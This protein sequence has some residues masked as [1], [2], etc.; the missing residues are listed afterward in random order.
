MRRFVLPAQRRRATGYWASTLTHLRASD[1]VSTSWAAESPRR[2][3]DPC[4]IEQGQEAPDFELPDQDGR[5]VKL[6][7]FRGQRVVIYFY[8]KAGT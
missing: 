1:A 2:G 6:S 8:P 5:A 3:Y 4:V 7:D